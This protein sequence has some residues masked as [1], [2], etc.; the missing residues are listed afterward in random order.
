M[1][2]SFWVAALVTVLLSGTAGARPTPTTAP[3]LEL[4][5]LEGKTVRL[6]DFKGR[7]LLVDIWASW[8]GPCKSSFP[9]LDAL[10]LELHPLGLD[11]LAVNVDERRR[12]ADE[13]LS[14][15]PH[16]MPVVLDPQGR[17]PEAFGAEAMP[18]SF[19]IDRSGNIRFRHAGYSPASLPV[20]RQEIARLLEEAGAESDGVVVIGP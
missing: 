2:P 9:S 15:H 1:R 12:D 18:S 4:T 10:Y 16:Q 8:C 13:F 11:L 14:H 6:A 3:T 7:V 17:V 5:T 20:Y 19:L